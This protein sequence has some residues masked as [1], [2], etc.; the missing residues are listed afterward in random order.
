LENS[1]DDLQEVVT[2]VRQVKGAP[3][4]FSAWFPGVFIHPVKLFQR[5]DERGPRSADWIVPTL[6]TIALS[7]TGAAL[8]ATIDSFAASLHDLEETASAVLRHSA[9][10]L[11]EDIGSVSPLGFL[12][13]YPIIAPIG[14]WFGAAFCWLL[15]FVSTQRSVSFREC[16]SILGAMTVVRIMGDLLSLLVTLISG[17]AF[18][19]NINE[20][21]TFDLVGWPAVLAEAL[22]P[23][24]VYQFAV[25][26]IGL[27]VFGAMTKKRAILTGTALILL[28]IL[29]VYLTTQ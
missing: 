25:L 16:L 27:Y 15:A 17:T 18:S 20:L 21:L 12:L 11:Q 3:V 28:Y 6:V 7:F 1:S 22:Q 19:F 9:L 13:L 14:I 4:P 29:L 26:L 23:F 8:A 2:E 5:I 10:V 24:A